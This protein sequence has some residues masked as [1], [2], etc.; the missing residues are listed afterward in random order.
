MGIA[1]EGKA[2]E[3]TSLWIHFASISGLKRAQTPK[4][5]NCNAPKQLDLTGGSLIQDRNTIS[6]SKRLG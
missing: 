3:V 2:S 1:G 4:I 5:E 6:E